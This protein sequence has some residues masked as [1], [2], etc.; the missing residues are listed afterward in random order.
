MVAVQVKREKF[1][2]V[3]VKQKA[4]CQDCDETTLKENDSTLSVI[5]HRICLC[6]RNKTVHSLLLDL[7]SEC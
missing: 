2:A 1:S 6:T 4:L 3:F 7:C 5:K